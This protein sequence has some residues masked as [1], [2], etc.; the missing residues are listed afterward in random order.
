MAIG[1]KLEEAR[2][3]KGI[4]IR[5][6]SESTK[7]RGNYLS[8]FEAGNFDLSIPDVYL[9]GFVKLYA[10]FLD[11]DQEAT[12][13]DL[14]IEL[15]ASPRKPSRK[16]LG[17]LPHGRGEVHLP[18][19]DIHVVRGS[20]LHGECD[21]LQQATLGTR[22][23]KLR[24]PVRSYEGADGHHVFNARRAGRTD[25]QARWGAARSRRGSGQIS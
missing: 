13:S 5:E 3:R 11:L 20:W 4:S 8:A 15:G 14:D 10:R 2:N 16:S 17:S 25:G 19:S 22:L 24:G 6:A 9:R 21:M 23:P 7:I 18:R 1:Q 12:V